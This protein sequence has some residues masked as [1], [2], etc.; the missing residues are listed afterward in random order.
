MKKALL[1]FN[2][3][4]DVII[5]Q[6]RKKNNHYLKISPC[7]AGWGRVPLPGVDEVLERLLVAVTDGNIDVAK[8]DAV[9]LNLADFALLHN[10]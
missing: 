9:A 8:D 10:E 7:G 5:F 3:A 2:N 4:K 1:N 6:L